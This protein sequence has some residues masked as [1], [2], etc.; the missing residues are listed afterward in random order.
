M[1]ELFVCPVCS[2]LT[3]LHESPLCEY[4]DAFARMIQCAECGSSTH[5]DGFTPADPE[6]AEGQDDLF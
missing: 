4:G 5:E 2:G 6:D 1:D 3:E